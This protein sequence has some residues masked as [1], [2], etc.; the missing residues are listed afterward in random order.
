MGSGRGRALGKQGSA[1]VLPDPKSPNGG[2][3][4]ISIG[5]ALAKA[6]ISDL[7]SYLVQKHTRLPMPPR[8]RDGTA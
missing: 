5:V 7:R 8:Q 3:V 6:E 4:T 1:L 2:T